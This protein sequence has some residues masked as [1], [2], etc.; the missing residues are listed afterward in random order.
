VILE[1]D[2]G[3]ASPGFL[4]NQNWRGC[5]GW[6]REG[7]SGAQKDAGGGT[8]TRDSEGGVSDVVSWVV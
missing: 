5:I 7:V 1:R 4:A 6:S 2:E 3:Q 8:G